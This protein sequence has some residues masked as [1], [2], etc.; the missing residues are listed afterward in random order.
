MGGGGGGGRAQRGEVGSGEKGGEGKG[1]AGPVRDSVSAE[2]LIRFN[3]DANVPRNVYAL[4][5]HGL[6]F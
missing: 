4:Y 3:D 6:S 2:R 5:K 1:G